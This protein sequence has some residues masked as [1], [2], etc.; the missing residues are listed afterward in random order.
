[1]ASLYQLTGNFMELQNLIESGEEIHPDNLEALNDAIE[2]K[3]EGYGM[4]IRNI[5]SNIDAH[6][7]EEERI[8]KNRKSMEN[9]LKRIKEHVHHSLEAIGKRRV[10]AN[11]FTFSIRSNPPSVKVFDE[12][13]L[14]AQYFVMP[15]PIVNKKRL[16]D[17]LKNGEKINGAE[18]SRGESLVIK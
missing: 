10:Q 14:P 15:E 13:L 8:A 6:K 1:M 17:D 7:A 12:S 16:A 4:L 11:L 3:L 18:L 9:N 5:Q 2:D